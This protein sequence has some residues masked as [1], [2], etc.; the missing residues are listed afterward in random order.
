MRRTGIALLTLTL[1]LSLTA[2]GTGFNAETRNITQITDG[3]EGAIINNQ[4]EIKVRNL[5]IVETAEK[6]GVIVGTLINTSDTDDALLG[7]AVNA[8]V[9]TLS[10]NTTLSKNSPIIFEGTSANAKA[11]VA[12]L[13]VVAGQ[14][15][16]VTLFFARGGEL[17][18]TA[19]VRDQR[20]TYAGITAQMDT[21]TTA[22]K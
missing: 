15:V 13:D 4:S 2:C 5:L 19:I 22:K 14:N 11:V 3:V 6:A 7:L 1:V 12:S 20:D 8:K 17:T 16:T 21:V 10:G 18:L 9:A